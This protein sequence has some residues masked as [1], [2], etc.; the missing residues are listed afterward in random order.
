MD[1]ATVEHAYLK[2]Y[3]EYWLTPGEFGDPGFEP[4]RVEN[5]RPIF[6][7][8]QITSPAQLKLG[9]VV[10]FHSAFAEEF[11]AVVLAV[12]DGWLI[13]MD[14]KSRQI[15]VESL[16]DHSVIHYSVISPEGWNLWH[17]IVDTGRTLSIN[18]LRLR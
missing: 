18:D 15:L 2:A 13:S 11:N 14:I 3:Q 16:K 4:V 12:Q 8:H 6:D 7:E 10:T 17:Y 9:M 1:E 5:N